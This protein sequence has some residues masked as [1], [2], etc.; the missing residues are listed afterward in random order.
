MS[1]VYLIK[2]NNNI[3]G[4]YDDLSI[5]NDFIL[6]LYNSEIISNTSE[7]KISEIKINSNVIVQERQQ[8][9]SNILKQYQKGLLFFDDYNKYED[10]SIVSTTISDSESDSDQINNIIIKTEG[11][12]GAKDI[13]EEYN[14]T[15][16]VNVINDND[17]RLYKKYRDLVLK[18]KNYRIPPFFKEKY[19]YFL[20]AEEENRTI[21]I[22]E[23]KEESY[24]EIKEKRKKMK[25]IIKQQDDL[26]Q[27]KID[28]VNRIN[29][30]RND[31]KK[32]EE[33]HIEY[34]YNL[35]LYYKFKQELLKNSKFTVPCLFIDKYELFDKLEKEKN[36]SF[37]N[38]INLYKPVQVSTEYD[39]LFDMPNSNTKVDTH[40]ESCNMKELEDAL[41]L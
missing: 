34:E 38:F 22:T 29:N 30:L 15:E 10:S 39:N 19:N 25:E 27:Q 28:I 32:I 5:I 12:E 13:K 7:I 1:N 23:V 8:P 14:N 33:Q 18:N 24:H 41:N 26:G 35:K 9:I 6:T 21:N 17:V 20:Q 2:I 11:V 36:L 37:E 3:C 31:K 16:V 40:F 4:I